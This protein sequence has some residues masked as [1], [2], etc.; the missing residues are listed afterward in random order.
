MNLMSFGRK[1]VLA[2]AFLPALLGSA[3]AQ[4]IAESHLNAARAA[5][6]AIKAT[7]Q[8]DTILPRAAETLREELLRKDPNLVDQINTVVNDKTV[9]LAGRRADL[10]TE[11]ARAYARVFTEVELNGITEFYTTPAGQKLLS[12]GPIVVRE[13]IKAANIWQEGIA[14]DLAVEVGKELQILV[15]PTAP[16]TEVA[17]V[18]SG[19]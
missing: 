14:R 1:A 12:D 9:L 7:D 15:P 6:T 3:W 19:G 13:L 5:I 16:V 11:S 10:E 17:P 2:A 18:K 8:F 4:E